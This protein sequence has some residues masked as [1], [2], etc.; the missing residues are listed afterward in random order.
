MR[1]GIPLQTI[2]RFEFISQI[3]CN[4][5][6]T[7][8]T[9]PTSGGLLPNDRFMNGLILNV[10]G[11]VTNAGSGNPSS[12][13]NGA[14]Y[15]LIESVIVEGYHRL[16][17]A[18]E[19]F[20]NLRGHD[21]AI[22]NS[23]YSAQANSFL[24]AGG[25]AVGASVAN[26]FQFQLYV[27]FAPLGLPLRQK[28]GWLLDA[29]NY[30]RLS[31]KIQWADDKSIFAGQTSASTFS[32]YGGT[33]GSPTIDVLGEFALAGSQKFAGFVPGRVWRYH[34]E[35]SGSPMTTTANGVRLFNLPRGFRLR[36]L[37]LKTGVKSTT[38]TAGNNAY[39]SLS[40]G[41]LSQIN[42]FRG[43][44]RAIR[45]YNRFEEQRFVDAQMRGIASPTGVVIH[46]FVPGGW[47]GEIL[48]TSSLTAGPTGDV[49]CYIQGNV[50]GAAN[51]A[52][53]LTLEE[54]RQTPVQA[55]G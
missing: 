21:L 37:M 5:V 43:L 8:Y 30:D 6:N 55:R 26:D 9:L 4:N 19:Q 48:D 13:L 16:R 42:V 45:F 39:V 12:V 34:Q 14:P 27:P 1:M 49:D 23:L 25:L 54:W 33:T 35:I 2:S 24:P 11:R 29:P 41:V 28:I 10:R 40:D 44:N 46:D 3:V 32:A 20:I 7:A 15:S 38:T 17:G 18:Q 50:T 51:Q 36:S 52:T 31:L 47:D 53:L 22:L